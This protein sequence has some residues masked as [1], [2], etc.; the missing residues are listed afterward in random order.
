MAAIEFPYYGTSG[1]WSPVTSSGSYYF[2]SQQY[3]EN[4]RIVA[5]A[6]VARVTAQDKRERRAQRNRIVISDIARAQGLQAHCA[7][8]DRQYRRGKRQISDRL[9]QRCRR[10]FRGR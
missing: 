10:V 2:E 6:E 4:R 3:A 7:L 8:R 1:S 9:A 5:K